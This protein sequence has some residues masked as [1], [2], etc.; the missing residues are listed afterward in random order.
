MAN[1]EAPRQRIGVF[2]GTFDPPHM[3]H[4]RLAELAVRELELDQLQIIPTGNAWYKTRQ[5]TEA[6]HRLAL[7]QLAFAAC[8]RAVV[9]DQELTRVGACYTIDTL[10][11]LRQTFPNA[12]FFLIMGADQAAKFN[13]WHRWQDILGLAELAVVDRQPIAASSLEAQGIHRFT[14]L[15]MPSMPI[16]ATAIRE[17]LSRGVVPT[18]LSSTLLAPAVARYIQHHQLY[19]APS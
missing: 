11:H 10:R 6:N 17:Q 19:K 14:V 3:G 16:S 7:A 13:T 12:Y 4:L 1:A 2:G 18:S 8:P 15:E 9:D 5:L